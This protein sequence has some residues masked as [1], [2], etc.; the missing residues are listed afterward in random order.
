MREPIPRVGEQFQARSRVHRR[1]SSSGSLE[2][3]ASIATS[4]VPAVP[5]Q[6][7]RRNWRL[8]LLAVLIGWN[9]YQVGRVIGGVILVWLIGAGGAV[10]GRGTHQSRLRDLGGITLERLGPPVQ[11][12]GCRPPRRRSGGSWPW[13]LLVAGVGL[14]GLFTASVASLLV[15]RYLRRT[16]RVELRD[17]R[18]SGAL[19]LGT[20]RAGVDSRGPQQDHHRAAPDRDHPRQP[21]RDRPARQAGRAGLQRRL[22]R[23]GRPDQ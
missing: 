10:P 23:Q 22:H 8:T 5:A 20:A 2:P 17:G 21:R 14:A 12:S 1:S 3:D 9:R 6:L 19:Q 7:K 18:P 11:R 13:C 16:R 15:E 4:L